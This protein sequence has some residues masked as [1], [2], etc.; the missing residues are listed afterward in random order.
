MSD[1]VERLNAALEGR[2]V[3]DRE[4]GEGGMATVYLAEDVRH[5]RKVALKVLR[6]DLAA[7]LGTERFLRE[8]EI[9]ANLTHPHILPLHDSGEADGFLFYVLPYVEGESLRD[10]LGREGELPVS[11]TIRILRDVVDALAHAHEHGVVHRDI[12]PDN[13]MLSGRHA[14]VTD[15]GVAKA[16]SQATGRHQ[17]T[18][19]GVALGTPAYMAPEQAEASD[20]IDHRADI[21]AVGAMAYELL[22]GAPPF[23][24]KSPQATLVAHLTQAPTPVTEHR[25]TVPI[26]LSQLVM[27]CLEKKP[28]DRW[29]SSEE[30][31]GH[32]EALATPSGGLTPMG[33]APVS[34]VSGSRKFLN[35][36]MIGAAALVVATGVFG[37]RIFTDDPIEISLSNNVQV[38]SGPQIDFEPDLSDD[39]A[40]VTYTSALGIRT[41]VMSKSLADLVGGRSLAL[42]QDLGGRQRSPRFG[43]NNLV[44]FE[45]SAGA[46][47]ARM[48]W[49][50]ATGG[51]TREIT[52]DILRAGD[53]DPSAERA[54]FVTGDSIMIVDVDERTPTLLTVAPPPGDPHSLSWSPDGQ[55]IA[56]VN[57]NSLF[58]NLRSLGNVATSSIWLAHIDGGDP[59][60]VTDRDHLNMSPAWLPDS[61]HLLFVSDREGA[62]DVFVVR[63][64]PDGAEGEP[65]RVGVPEPSSISISAD[66][67]RLAY[68]KFSFSRNIR[69]Y[70]IGGSEPLSATEGN[71]V[72]SGNQIVE[73]HDL[74]SDGEFI[75]YDS[76]RSGN[77]DVFIQ[78]LD[79][80]SYRQLTTNPAN[81][82]AGDLSPDGA[83]LAFYSLRDGIRRIFV[84]PINGGPEVKV[85][86]DS[87][88]PIVRR[89][90]WSPDGLSI[91][92]GG[93]R[94]GTWIVN[95]DRVGGEWSPPV[96]I[97]SMGGSYGDW[98]PDGD[99]IVFSHE[100]S[101]WRRTLDGELWRLFRAAPGGANPDDLVE[102]SLVRLSADGST[103]YFTGVDRSD[104]QGVWSV[105]ARG[106]QRCEM[107]DDPAPVCE[108]LPLPEPRLMVEFDS[109]SLILYLTGISVS[110]DSI[111][112]SV[113]SYQSDIW[114]TD[115]EW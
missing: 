40:N 48:L 64:G 79:D 92:F 58:N 55:W 34:A 2:Y 88:H 111:Y 56:F 109:P 113:G 35:P 93:P 44:L 77:Q 42:A 110:S 38:T 33:T 66:G 65:E 3:I 46:G 115:L 24:G 95:R 114:V 16:V 107:S 6:P 60:Q 94:T 101:I 20:Q 1:A 74:S 97:T 112:L 28:A 27:R 73:T 98:T 26:L 100:G 14:L 57:G 12:K 18:T 106:G 72:T 39:G 52:S 105:P 8:I 45:Q 36:V 96:L 47:R 90:T 51:T 82:F 102:T 17:L 10:R 83:E 71:Q 5:H 9:A 32:L 81:D 4:L 22:A 25:P 86:V 13:I 62:R 99:Q 103:A 61:R 85:S 59:V 104:K 15:F 69:S 108:D 87:L 30:M 68:A 80:E 11:E 31:L 43:S 29:Q 23:S 50:S 84:K 70:P 19:M 53:W 76:N 63:V 75:V 67:T 91:M 41:S 54:T 49:V 89:P 37:W 78:S 7:S 21:Y